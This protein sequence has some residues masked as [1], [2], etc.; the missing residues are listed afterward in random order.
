MSIFHHLFNLQSKCRDG[1]RDAQNQ[2]LQ[3]KFAKHVRYDSGDNRK[4][5]DHAIGYAQGDLGFEDSKLPIL[6]GKY[7]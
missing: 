5:V 6:H 1:V 3:W 4:V 2:G 7:N